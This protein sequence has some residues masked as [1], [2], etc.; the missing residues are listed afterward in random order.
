M[1]WNQPPSSSHSPVTGLFSGGPCREKSTNSSPSEL[2][3]H[4]WQQ[5]PY[6]L[7][8]VLFIAPHFPAFP[9][10]SPSWPPASGCFPNCQLPFHTVTGILCWWSGFWVDWLIDVESEM[11]SCVRLFVIPQTIQLMEF[12]RPG[13]WSGW[14]FPSP[15]IFPTQWSNPGLP[16]CRRILY[17]LSHKESPRILTWIAYPFSSGSSWPRNQTK[18]SCIAGRFF[19]NWAIRE[20]TSSNLKLQSHIGV[21]HQK[22][23]TGA[24]PVIKDIFEL[25]ANTVA[26][27][28]PWEPNTEVK[29]LVTTL[30][31]ILCN[32]MDCGLPKNPC[33]FSRQEYWSELLCPPTGE[34]SQPVDW[35]RVSHI[36]DRFFTVWATREAPTTCYASLSVSRE[37]E[38]SWKWSLFPSVNA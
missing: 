27:C 12:C 14:L 10:L 1:S 37:S 19:T 6:H 24:C 17:Q 13:Y 25:L 16:H 35:T 23:A 21:A 20:K 22:R 33:R 34:S 30:C 36:A 29:V 9:E 4:Y 32:L 11:L 8:F 31:P 2:G 3:Q 26:C 28:L 38:Y 5:V 18:V 7:L 15:G